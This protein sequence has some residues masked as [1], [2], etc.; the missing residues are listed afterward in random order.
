MQDSS[1]SAVPQLDSPEEVALINCDPEGMDDGVWYLAH[2]KRNTSNTLQ[3]PPKIAVYLRPAGYKIETVIAK[4]GHLFSTCHH[5]FRA[6]GR[7]RESAEV[8]PLAESSSYASH[9]RAR[10][11]SLFHS[12]EP[13]G[14][15]FVLRDSSP[16]AASRQGSLSSTWNTRATKCLEEAGEGSFYVRRP[17]LLVSE[18]ERIWGAR[19]L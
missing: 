12:G 17:H 2:L 1:G 14:R 6:S 19:S 9:R 7:G 15:W 4:N 11:G 8:W 18:P 13:Q 5:P 10:A 3:V 16:G